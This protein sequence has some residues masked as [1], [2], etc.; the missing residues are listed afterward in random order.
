MV[1]YEPETELHQNF[2]PE[3]EPHKIDAAPQHWIN[4]W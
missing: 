1:A 3:P 2:R 4:F